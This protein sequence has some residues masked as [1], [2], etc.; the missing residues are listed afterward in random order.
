MSALVNICM[1]AKD[2]PRLTQQAI[3]SLLSATPR[4]LYNLTVIDDGSEEPIERFL[5]ESNAVCVRLSRS[6]GIVGFARNLSIRMSEQYWGRGGFLCCL[7][8]DIFALPG[9]LEAMTQAMTEHPAFAIV[10]GCRHPYHGINS[11][12]GPLVATDAVAG[13]SMMM[14]WNH[15][16]AFGPFDSH[17]VG[18]GQSEDFAVSRRAVDDGMLVGYM[19]PS[20]IWHTGITNTEG[21]PATGSE[22]FPRVAGILME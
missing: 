21:R 22:A 19:D 15:W 6:K 14:R 10:G 11:T 3:Q 9:W 16:G 18:L 7:D 8:N 5:K 17:A 1:I 12:H 2:R 4:E 13:Y 20:V